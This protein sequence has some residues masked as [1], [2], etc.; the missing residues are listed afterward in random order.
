LD[1]D[2]NL[3]DEARILDLLENVSDYELVSTGALQTGNHMDIDTLLNPE[4]KRCVMDETMDEE[5][6]EAVMESRR[7]E[8]NGPMNSGDD[9]VDNDACIEARPT[10]RE[11]MQAASVMKRYIDN[12]DDLFACKLE[13]ILGS[14]GR[15]MRLDETHFMVPTQMTDYFTRL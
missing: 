6:F 10:C 2:A 3:V 1:N 12:L 13:A 14:F 15:Q 5:I 7:A 4:T 11:A 9:D 8:E